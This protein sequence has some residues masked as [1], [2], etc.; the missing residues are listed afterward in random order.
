M[1]FAK[2]PTPIPAP[3]AAPACILLAF[4]GFGLKLYLSDKHNATLQSHQG[5]ISRNTIA[6]NILSN[7]D[8]KLI[9]SDDS[10]T[11][12]GDVQLY[13]DN[14]G[15]VKVRQKDGKERTWA[16]GKGV[17]NKLIVPY[18]KRSSLTLADGS[19]IWLNSGSTLTF[20][21]Q[22]DDTKRE[23]ELIS[24]E[25]YVE[26]APDK[27]K[28]FYVHTS[29]YDVKVYGTKLNVSSYSKSPS[30]V[31]LVE[32]SVGL[33]PSTRKELILSPNER[34]VLLEDGSIRTQKV[35]VSLFV[36]WKDGYIT[37]DNTPINEVL[38]QIGRYY[39]LF[40]NSMSFN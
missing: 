9:I 10:L 5:T 24:G 39:N 22:F 6:G 18:G 19:K 3:D 38:R 33:K 29:D 16:V 26:V 30:S 31:V 21:G 1:A 40:F 25:L 2:Y 11:F 12:H 27:N 15:Q 36:S 14:N 13:I 37:Y 28:P 4:I 7:E 20:P 34:T 35:D 23:I 17:Q 8:V 32:G